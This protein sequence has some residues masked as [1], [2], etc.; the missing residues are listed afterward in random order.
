VYDLFAVSNH[1]GNMSEGHYTAMACNHRT[2]R[3]FEFN[4]TFVESVKDPETSLRKENAYVL[5]YKRRNI[6]WKIAS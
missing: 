1:E 2:G 3:W 6:D 4:D 5:F